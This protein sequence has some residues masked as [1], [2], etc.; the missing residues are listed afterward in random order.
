MEQLVYFL[1]GCF[2]GLSAGFLLAFFS[3]RCF[4]ADKLKEVCSM[5][6]SQKCKEVPNQFGNVKSERTMHD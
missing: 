1:A 3:I 2:V 6:E 5:I 4:L